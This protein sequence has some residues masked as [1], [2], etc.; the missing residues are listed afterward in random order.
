MQGC[1]GRADIIALSPL[2]FDIHYERGT[3]DDLHQTSG[4]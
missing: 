2:C 3:T 4:L 1:I